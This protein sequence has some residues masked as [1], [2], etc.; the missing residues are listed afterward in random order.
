M[1]STNVLIWP[2]TSQPVFLLG[3]G[4]LVLYLSRSQIE[5]SVSILNIRVNSHSLT[6]TIPLYI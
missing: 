2:D 1:L 5:K 3:H 4:L 6:M